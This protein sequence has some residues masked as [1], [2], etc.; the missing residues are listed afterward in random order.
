MLIDVHNHYYPDVYVDF[1]SKRNENPKIFEVGNKKFIS[2][3]PPGSKIAMPFSEKFY[4]IEKKIKI[5]NDAGIDKI[6]ISLGNP[7]T[8][9]FSPEDS[10]RL[11]KKVNEAIA[12]CVGEYP[13]KIFGLATVPLKAKEHYLEELDR[14]I[15]ELG[16]HGVVVG[17]NIDGV[18]LDH[19]DFRPFFKRAEELKIPIFLHPTTPP[20]YKVMEERQL[21]HIV[22]FTSETSLV[23]GKLI[24]SGILEEFPS[25]K[26]VAPHGGG[27]LPYLAGRFDLF[28]KADP[29]CQ[30]YAKNPPSHYLKKLYYD[31]IVYSPDAL[32]CVYSLAGPEHMLFGT[33]EPFPLN[34]E[35][36]KKDI[37]SLNLSKEEESR[38]YYKN[39]EKLLSR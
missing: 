32:R 9:F 15:L 26:I 36:L 28:Y 38:I 12:E 11:A 20:S 6:V 25:L 27:T 13:D 33:D 37:T 21:V 18:Y 39:A 22:G 35:E 10:A 23:V 19:S 2:G 14:A 31:C 8:D 1:L 29:R 7:W 17:T 24:F 34:I 3:H 16:L 5:A 4:D 30:E